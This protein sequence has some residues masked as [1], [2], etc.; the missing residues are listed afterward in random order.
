LDSLMNST[1][2]A[3]STAPGPTTHCRPTAPGLRA[4]LHKV[5][6]GAAVPEPHHPS[7][8]CGIKWKPGTRAQLTARG[9]QTEVGRRAD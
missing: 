7:M 8:G 3:S 9:M 1:A 5:L 4:A 6:T 2:E